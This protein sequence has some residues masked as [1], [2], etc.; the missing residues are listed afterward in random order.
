M[1]NYDI[2]IFKLNYNLTKQGRGK[3]LD[4]AMRQQ[5][6]EVNWGDVFCFC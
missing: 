1:S 4:K 3:D 5:R 2:I 6:K